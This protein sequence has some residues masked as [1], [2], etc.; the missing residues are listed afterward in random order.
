[1]AKRTNYR[2]TAGEI[3]KTIIEN[4]LLEILLGMFVILIILTIWLGGVVKVIERLT[5]FAL[6]AVLSTILVLFLASA[7]G[8]KLKN[9]LIKKLK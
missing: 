4:P 5:F 3:K 2:K 7:I 8:I 9:K 1:M 6:N